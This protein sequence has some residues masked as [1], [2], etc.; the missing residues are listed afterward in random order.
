VAVAV[1]TLPSTPAPTAPTASTT[2]QTATA[3]ATAATLPTTA[4][5]VSTATPGPTIPSAAT[6][7]PDGG[8]W[9]E[10][11]AGLTPTVTAA[12]ESGFAFTDY[13]AVDGDDVMFVRVATVPADYEWRTSWVPGF[14]DVT[15]SADVVE[16][17]GAP[18][19]AASRFDTDGGLVRSY[20]VRPTPTELITVAYVDGGDRSANEAS[21]FV[22]SFHL[23]S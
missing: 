8:W 20:V 11:P 3:T 16:R 15:A 18:W 21:A 23:T 7:A 5:P 13:R 22:G 6:V 19:A 1:T 9:V 12:S 10:F 17:D 2:G 14:P 4:P